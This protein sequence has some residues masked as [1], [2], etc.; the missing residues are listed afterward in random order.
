M[1]CRQAKLASLQD[2][3][4]SRVRSPDNKTNSRSRHQ[5]KRVGE[6]PASPLRGRRPNPSEQAPDR[7]HF[8]PTREGSNDIE[9]LMRR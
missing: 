4:R 1:R 7:G 9:H 5:P 8:G 6:R 3:A 2:L